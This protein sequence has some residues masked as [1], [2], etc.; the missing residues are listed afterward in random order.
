MTERDDATARTFV[1]RYP[2]GSSE[3]RMSQST[4]RAGDV[5]VGR[6]VRW[7]VAE[8]AEYSR[9]TLTIR[10]QSSPNA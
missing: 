3:F 5:V 4:P 1:I 8:V 2:D 9:G 7:L 6:G 10:L